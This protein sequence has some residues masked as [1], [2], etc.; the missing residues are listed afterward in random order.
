M[1]ERLD[2]DLLEILLGQVAKNRE[3]DVILGEAGTILLK[4]Q[5]L[6]QVCYLL[7]RV[8][9]AVLV[10]SNL[11]LDSEHVVVEQQM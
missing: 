1:A 3:I 11:F 4:T 7:H 6:E 8:P 2:P 10:V 9:P 5:P